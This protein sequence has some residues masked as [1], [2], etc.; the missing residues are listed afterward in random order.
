MVNARAWEGLPGHYKQA[1]EAAG[2]ECWHWSMARFDEL[3]PPAMRRLLAGGTQLRPY[4]R[5]ILAAAYKASQ[6]LYSELGDQNPRFRKVWEHWNKH[7]VE[8]SAVVPRRRGFH[9]ELRRGRLGPAPLSLPT[10]DGGP[11]RL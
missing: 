7:R 2:A 5:D 1:M 3:A 10:T 6:D 11:G 9:G 4:S 8:Q